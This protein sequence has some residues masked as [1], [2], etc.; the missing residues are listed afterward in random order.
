L[1]GIIQAVNGFVEREESGDGVMS[2][3]IGKGEEERELGGVV[4][5]VGGQFVEGVSIDEALP[6]RVISPVG[7]GVFE[8]SGAGAFFFAGAA[9]VSVRVSP[10][11]DLGTISGYAEV[12]PVNQAKL[13]GAIHGHGFEDGVDALFEVGE[14]QMVGVLLDLGGQLLDDALMFGGVS[15]FVL[16]LSLGVLFFRVGFLEMVLGLEADESGLEVEEGADSG[17]V[18][19]VKAREEGIVGDGAHLVHPLV[20]GRDLTGF[21]QRKGAEHILWG[22]SGSPSG[23]AIVGYYD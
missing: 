8:P 5:G 22:D 23:Q 13:Y 4:Q 14:C 1:D 9:F 18:L 19:W 10:G 21:H 12:V 16:G 15:V 7:L 17:D 11:W 2:S 6:V 20:D 3:G